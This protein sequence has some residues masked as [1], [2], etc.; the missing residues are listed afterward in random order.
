MAWTALLPFHTCHQKPHFSSA[1]G[2]GPG[3]GGG[4]VGG[5][6]VGG[7]PGGGGPG[8]GAGGGGDINSRH[9]RPLSRPD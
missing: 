4:P 8:G 3:G 7:G 1:G 9:G 2:G 6:P 5:G